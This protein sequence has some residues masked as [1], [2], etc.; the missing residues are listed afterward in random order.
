[1]RP[2]RLIASVSTVLVAAGMLTVPSVALAADPADSQDR[3]VLE[4]SPPVDETT[5]QVRSET[6][7]ITPKAKAADHPPISRARPINDLRAAAK[8]AGETGRSWVVVNGPGDVRVA[9]WA[10][11]DGGTWSL[12]VTTGSGHVGGMTLE[13]SD[14]GGRITIPRTGAATSDVRIRLPWGASTLPKGDVSAF[15]SLA[16]AG[17]EL[18]GEVT[19]SDTAKAGR[20]NMSGPVRGDGE[21][22]AVPTVTDRVLRRAGF[23]PTPACCIFSTAFGS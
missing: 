19:A 16:P 8:C 5:D 17:R 2:T 6:E 21:G 12:D 1:M 14:F 15:L 3:I 10:Q 7:S 23:A 18:G 13:A 4:P 9:G 20:I 11:C 22:E